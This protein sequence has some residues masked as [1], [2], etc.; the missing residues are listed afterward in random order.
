MK[1]LAPNIKRQRLLIEG[2]YQI[3]VN[4]DT[5]VEFF[6]SITHSL[7]LR[8]YGEPIIFSPGGEG[9]EENQGYDAF[10]PLIDSG[11]SLYIWSN[12]RFVSLII[13]TCKSFD[14]QIALEATKD[15]FK[16]TEVESQEF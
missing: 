1:D 10:V 13:Y 5:I 6:K 9:K 4:K 16:I 8:M 7:N 12:A 3:N 11:I 2:F 15:F 14:G